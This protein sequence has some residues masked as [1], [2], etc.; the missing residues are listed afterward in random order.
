MQNHK[1]TQGG[2]FLDN[3]DFILSQF[4]GHESEHDKKWSKNNIYIFQ[5]RILLNG[6]KQT[7]NALQQF[8]TN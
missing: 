8:K 3:M 2:Q 7:N 4:L 6:L 1:T 5:I